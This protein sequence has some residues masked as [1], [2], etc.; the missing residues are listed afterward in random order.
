MARTKEAQATAEEVAAAYF[1]AVG[2]R[3]VD[4]M[5]ECWQLPGTG[6]IHG[7]AE[8]KAPEG[9]HEWFGTLF[10]AFPD[11]KFEVTQITANEDR[12]A[13]QW[14]ATGGFT[15]D[16]RFEGLEPNGARIDIVGCDVVSVRE[17]K[18]VEVNA[19]T[20]GT[21]VARQLGGLPPAGSMPEKAMLGALNLKTKIAAAI[22]RS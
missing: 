4:A 19:Y 21:E 1:E 18:V 22:G 15:G 13:V 8:L 5:M 17:G 10:R 20:N 14:R 16:A 2:N 7:M 11:W 6:Y 3:D 9:Y 12:A